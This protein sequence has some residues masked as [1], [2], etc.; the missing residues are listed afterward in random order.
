M[1]V[2]TTSFQNPTGTSLPAASRAAL[3]RLAHEHRVV[4]VE[5]DIYGDLRY[6]GER[7]P[8]LKQMDA[9]GDTILLRSF[10]KT[11]FPGLRVGWIIAPKEVTRRVAEAKQWCDLHTDQLSQAVLLRFVESGRLASHRAHMLSAGRERLRAALDACSRH[12]SGIASFTRPE[13]GMSL[14]VTFADPTDTAD[15][16]SRAQREGVAYLPG[17]H[18]AVTR[19]HRSSARLSFAGLPPD[20]IE[21]GI[22]VLGR[23]F[24]E[25]TRRVRAVLDAEP[26]PALV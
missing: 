25:E 1:L 12:F 7:V 8:T 4:L 18:F 23:I 9:T 19:E 10:S 3:I 21:K 16:L 22:A 14:W 26:E 17:R 2:A 13:G 20:R 24:Q 5:N 11:A 15:L 6:E